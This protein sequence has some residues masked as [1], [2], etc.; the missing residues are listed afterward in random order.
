MTFDTCPTGY[1]FDGVT[2]CACVNFNQYASIL[3][4]ILVIILASSVCMAVFGVF[5][6]YRHRVGF[7]HREDEDGTTRKGLSATELRTIFRQISQTQ[8]PVNTRNAYV[9]SFLGGYEQ[10]D[11]A[12]SGGDA[13]TTMLRLPGNPKKSASA[14]VLYSK[15]EPVPEREL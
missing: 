11:Q 10:I 3:L 12:T 6:C 4:E 2:A 15:L 8:N 14:D 5:Q 7:F 1:D 9:S 13:D